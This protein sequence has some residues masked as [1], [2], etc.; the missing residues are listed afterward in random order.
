MSWSVFFGFGLGSG[1]HL[2]FCFG[3]YY[4]F[5]IGRGLALVVFLDL[6]S[7]KN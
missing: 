3:S 6:V 1:L 5:W 2:G 7:N 4:G